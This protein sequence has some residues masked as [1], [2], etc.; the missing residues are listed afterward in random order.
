[1][2]RTENRKRVAERLEQVRRAMVD[3][4]A[5]IEPDAQFAASVLERVRSERAQG[6]IVDTLGWAALRLLPVAAVLAVLVTWTALQPQHGVVSL[7]L[8]SIG[9]DALTVFVVSGLEAE[10]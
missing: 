5:G 3:H 6:D 2:N 9:D 4:H 1:M 8:P 7:L 10:K